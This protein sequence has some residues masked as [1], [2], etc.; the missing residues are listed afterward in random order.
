MDSKTVWRIISSSGAVLWV[1]R[2]VLIH[3]NAKYWVVKQ[4]GY[5]EHHAPAHRTAFRTIFTVELGPISTS[6]KTSNSHCMFSLDQKEAHVC[7]QKAIL[8]NL[9]TLR[10]P[11]KGV[12]RFPCYLP[13]CWNLISCF[14][15]PTGQSADAPHAAIGDSRRR[16]PSHVSDSE[17]DRD[18]AEDCPSFRAT[19]GYDGVLA[20]Q[21]GDVDMD[22]VANFSLYSAGMEI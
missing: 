4:P 13:S 17:V 1:D 3:R 10:E 8:K 21:D 16:S 19:V 15:L 20:D 9:I 7:C 11:P 22:D 12:L 5:M 2:I 18:D 6:I 14:E